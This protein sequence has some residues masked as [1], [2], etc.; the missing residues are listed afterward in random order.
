MAGRWKWA[1]PS[2]FATI[3]VT[4]P[5][6]ALRQFIPGGSSPAMARR[7]RTGSAQS[8]PSPPPEVT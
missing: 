2:G 1:S 4:G 3:P 6:Y 5:C 8:V 7:L